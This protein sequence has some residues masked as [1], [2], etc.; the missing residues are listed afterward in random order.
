MTVGKLDTKAKKY[1]RKSKKV[2]NWKRRGK[3]VM[4][5]EKKQIFFAQPPTSST[6]SCPLMRNTE[7]RE[8]KHSQ[9]FFSNLQILSIKRAE[10]PSSHC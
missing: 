5:T 8:F 6:S 10:L 2:T 7:V 1:T 9:F 4:Q 3:K